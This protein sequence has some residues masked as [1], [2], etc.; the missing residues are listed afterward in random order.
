SQI[1]APSVAFHIP[2]IDLTARSD[3]HAA[4]EAEHIASMEAQRTF[5]LT[6]APLI[7][8]T[9]VRVRRDVSMLLVTA[10]HTVCDGWSVGILAHEMGEI[11]AA[12]H[13]GRAPSLPDIAVSYADYVAWE[14]E[15]LSDPSAL[16]AERA[17]LANKLRGFTAFEVRPDNTRP[18]VQTA[19]SEI[20]GILLERRLSDGLAGVAKK[21]NCTL[22][23]TA[24]A[25]LLALLHRTT[26]ETDIAL[27][28]QI[29][30]RED[31]AFEELVGAFI[32]TVP[33]RTDVSGDPTFRELLVRAR[34]TVSDAF[35]LRSVPLE[36]LVEILNPKRDLSRNSLFPINFVLQRS[37][38]DNKTYGSFRLVDLPSCSAGPICDLNFFMVERPEGWRASCEF[39]T[40][41]YRRETIQR[42]MER[43]VASMEAVVRDPGCPL[44]TL[45]A[46]VEAPSYELPEA[47]SGAVAVADETSALT[48]AELDQRSDRLAGF[49][50]GA[51][52][53][54]HSPI[55][56]A[57]EHPL[58]LPIVLLGIW[59]SGGAYVP[60]DATL[61]R[62]RLAAVIADARVQLVLTQQSLRK[63]FPEGNVPVIDL[64]GSGA[65]ER[66]AETQRPRHTAYNGATERRVGEILSE[67]IGTPSIDRD[68]DIFTI[69]F[70]SLLAV[71]FVARV[72]SAFGVELK[73]RAVFENPTIRAIGERIASLS[74]DTADVAASGPIVT[75]NPHGTRV[76]FIYL[77]S[78][79]FAEGLYAQKLAAA[80]G[81]DQPMH[82]VAP[83]GTFGLPLLPTIESMA[84]DYVA[85]IRT[86]QPHGPYRLGGFCASGLVAYEL[87]RILRS[88]GEVVDRLVLLNA[89]PMPS[90]TISVI[91][92]LI[93]RLGLDDR[94][95][96]LLRYRLCYNLAR[97]HAAIVSGP[98]ATLSFA[99][100]T[101]LSML[102][103][104][105][106]MADAQEL[107]PFEKRRGV[108]Q[109][110]NSFAH[111]VA[112]LTYHPAPHDGEAT[113]IW[114]ENQTTASDD[115]S[116]GWGP[117]LRQVRIEPIGGGHV[118]VLTERIE[119]LARVLD[120][121]L[122]DH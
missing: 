91:D 101:F 68:V 21:N 20:L 102:G 48:H 28:T 27:S 64:A 44:S 84:Q 104:S 19:N 122:R 86:V 67:L 53:G 70:H 88:Q 65:L 47:R 55:G 89:S 50:R 90:R 9:H 45:P 107:Q 76:P 119:E 58:D 10:H 23:M 95:E 71:R 103:R 7:R 34:D 37:F 51:G 100:K 26:G 110:E 98:R 39:N 15:W 77:H 61:P 46:A 83:H 14:R 66:R 118:A 4:A 3:A 2:I 31:V 52:V 82:A 35:E 13:A 41:L 1:V 106:G 120:T 94:R 92:T 93:R 96:P 111:L 11:C 108:V 97:F 59:K 54:P 32:N 57:L 36:D 80:L 87:A 60:L 117:L 30:G 43:W 121:V 29:A 16:A 38:I 72:Q 33:L 112:S 114:A 12:L 25:T 6:A 56:V 5:D 22:F 78:D 42:L 116:R 79:L 63:R 81:P 69:G 105:P 24:Y 62:E 85:L 8:V 113:L 73:L 17:A 49:L 99:K 115:P 74:E 18:P 109:T 40:D 75:L